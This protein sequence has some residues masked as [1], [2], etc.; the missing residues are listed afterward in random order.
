M[1]TRDCLLT[2]VFPKALEDQIIDFMLTRESQVAGFISGAVAGHGANAIYATAGERVRGLA[3][4]MRLTTIISQA[5]A[6]TL[7]NDLKSALGQANIVYWLSPLI[8]Y[9]SFV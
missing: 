4:Q 7:L 8:A 6:E 1:E 3:K 5:D 2:L 9:G